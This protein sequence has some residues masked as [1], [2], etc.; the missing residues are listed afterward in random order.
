MRRFAQILVIVSLLYGPAWVRAQAQEEYAA[1][2]AVLKETT[3]DSRIKLGEEFVV[4]YP[5]SQ[6]ISY[7]RQ[8]LVYDYNDKNNSSKVI[9]HGETLDLKDGVA[10]SFLT[11]AYS[12]KKD[13]A[14]TIDAAQKANQ[15]LAAQTEGVTDKQ[16]N[17]LS[18]HN[19]Y[20]IG[21]AY[22]NMA[23][24]QTGPA[25]S[26]LLAKARLALMSAIKLNPRDDTAHYELGLVLADMGE[27]PDA[28][29]AL[30]KAVV[31][32]GPVQIMAQSELERIYVHY[33]KNKTGLD[34]VLAK[35][36]GAK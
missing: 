19:Q 33:N 28:I 5:K 10:A 24:R 23:R 25:R 20:L 9:E 21:N 12:V 4:K 15:T 34:K 14:K 2:M 36:R 29:D 18:Q 22:A 8:R 27:G 7:V 6:Y 3:T 26:D 30:A 35:A 31:I 17:T 13:D 16:K 32:G 1:M 11:H